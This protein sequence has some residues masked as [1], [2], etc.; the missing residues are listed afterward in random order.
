M[1]TKVQKMVMVV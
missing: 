1:G